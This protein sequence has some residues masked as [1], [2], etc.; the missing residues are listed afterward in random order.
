M[1]AEVIGIVSIVIGGVSI[2]L[3]CVAIATSVLSEWRS[4]A[5]F[6]RTKD[7]LSEVTTTAERIDL[8]VGGTQEKLVDTVTAIANPQTA[9]DAMA[10][11]ANQEQEGE[12]LTMMTTLLPLMMSDPDMKAMIMKKFGEAMDSED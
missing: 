7:M 12:Q 9:V 10:T 4:R 5:N 8:Q 6:D 2:V 3:A 11:A 1:D